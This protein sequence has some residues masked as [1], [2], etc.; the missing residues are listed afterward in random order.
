MDLIY[1]LIWNDSLGAFTVASELTRARGK[2][3]RRA[4]VVC[5]LMLAAAAMGGQAQSLPTGAEITV[6][7]G[8]ILQTGNT[9]TITQDTQNLA[10][11]WQ[12]FNVGAN[13]T[14]RFAQPNA[15]AIAL[16]RVLGSDPS[17]I[18]GA[19]E[20]NGQVWLLNPNGV[21]FG[22]GAQVNVGGLVAST[23]NISDADFLAGNRTLSGSGNGH[24]VNYGNI[25]ARDG[26]YVALLGGQVSN[27]GVVTARLGTVALASGER[28]TLD[29]AG[30][31]LL[32][33]SV[34]E[35]A[36]GA[37]V[38][39]Q[40]LI[41]ADG[42]R[43]FMT[44]R[45]SNAVL[46]TVVNNSGIVEARTV[47]REGGVIKLLGGFE[48]GT[49][50]VGGTLDASAPDGGDGGFIDTSGHKVAVADGVRITTGA[51]AGR[52]G[53]WLIDP[54][55]YTIAAT[56]G[57]ITGADLSALL[58]DN[59]V[60]IRSVDGADAN[61]NGDI[62]VNDA[63][64]WGAETTLTLEAVRNIEISDMISNTGSGNLVLR[65]DMQGVGVGTVKFLPGGQVSMHDGRTDLYYNPAT[66]SAPTNYSG[67][68]TGA[69]TAWMLVND[70]DQLQAINGN[71][72]GR[73]AL[74]RDI[75]ASATSGWNGGA[76]FAPIGSSSSPFT[77]ALDGLNHSI[78][79][80][81]INR[82]EAGYVGLFSY[83]SSSAAVS[84]LG[85]VN[86]DVTG[87]YNV[88]ALA[89]RSQGTIDGSH[90]TGTVTGTS[91]SV[92]GLLGWLS[93]GGAI[94]QSHS[95]AAVS[96]T[97][98]QVGGLVGYV[99]SDGSITQS[100]ATGTV[101]GDDRIGGLVGYVNGRGVISQ[102]HASAEVSGD[103]YVGGLVG[104]L[105]NG[106]S[107]SQSYSSGPVNGSGNKV[108]GLV[109]YLYNG[110]TITQSYATGAVSGSGSLGYVGGLVGHVID[111]HSGNNYGPS[112]VTE[113]YAVNTV[114]AAPSAY[115]GGLFGL[116][117]SSVAVVSRS[118]W[119]VEVSGRSNA[120]GLFN[121]EG[122]TGLTTSQMKQ[123]SNFADWSISGSGGG[124]TA[125]RIY[126]GQTRPLLRSFLTPLTVT[127]DDA[128]KTYDGVA[129]TGGDVSAS[130]FR[131]GE[132]V[133]D[134]LGEKTYTG[135]AQGA[136]D[137]GSYT[138][139][140]SGFY[141]DQQGYDIE[142]VPGTLTIEKRALGVTGAT[143]QSR[144]YD[145]TTDVAIQG[146][147][148]IGVLGSDTVTLTNANVGSFADKH[149]GEGKAVST[150]M[151][152]SGADANNYVL[153]QPVG[154][155][156][157]ITP[158]ELLVSATG[159]NRVYDGT[160]GATVTLS[161]DR[162][163]GDELSLS[164]GSAEFADK[165]AGEGK[166]VSVAGITVTGADA[167]NYTWNTTATAT[168]DIDR[169][170]LSV[171]GAMAQSRVYDGTTDVA[172]QGATLSG[173]FGSDAVILTNANVGSFADKHVGEGK[174]VSTAMGLSGA[175]ANNYVLT[176]P[177]G[178]TADIT[179]RELLVSVTG[180]NRV[181]DG[182]TAAT[183]MLSDDRVAGDQLALSYDSAEFADAAPGEGKRINVL[184]IAVDGADARNYTWNT[185]AYAT[186]DIVA[187][188]APGPGQPGPG[189]GPG[190]DPNPDPG[191][192][193][194]PV[195][196]EQV[197]P[198]ITP[199]LRFEQLSASTLSIEGGIRLPEGL[200]DEDQQD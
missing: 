45:A 73:Y 162:V 161:D 23:L 180:Q 134:L 24:I 177:V 17:Q 81:Y 32:N 108:G 3:P 120:D 153:T 94:S 199:E 165:H 154:L 25:S 66:Y 105:H 76:G 142:Y 119:D 160:T 117:E 86:V 198:E 88:G 185:V 96:S 195:A 173:L 164:Y 22:N 64:T 34:D 179:P 49:V 131:P 111:D 69:H 127:V 16:N 33:V 100:Y 6:G 124:N 55:D 7:Q 98:S 132:G 42:G 149:V 18:H 121:I 150:A 190:P 146:A 186:A 62:F 75:D 79:G 72:V 57:D 114:A 13:E 113:S 169:A 11:N 123:A 91:D 15:S 178:L 77:G 8:S 87:S 151:G 103:M 140:V 126:E 182:T 166:S 40:E 116:L 60:V 163:A 93:D 176:Q 30:D 112:S 95:A 102:S 5:G 51:S 48:G 61:G 193:W 47:E 85:L 80:L 43:V 138:L 27:Q 52:T 99:S 4:R 28:V 145:G 9:L 175:D 19:I 106:S 118:V 125:W 78:D 68:I 65:S 97:Y 20:A 168:A 39:N 38:D 157:D 35:G 122:A 83:L 130:G 1:K 194:A 10:I 54:N 181:Y 141:S 128:T 115:A 152:L 46:E 192:P 90:S 2:C 129:W 184:G 74:G 56:D 170:M 143:A 159:Q 37:L 109:G 196:L 59:N 63:V 155:T 44:A 144:V 200:V 31:A 50:N 82:P 135:T 41:R 104:W 136:R 189:P 110:S 26:G 107:V 36:L 147:T 133:E 197:L 172:I 183:V 191:E 71:L 29:F 156:A 21:L 148:L 53:T 158:R 67:N 92:G 101:S 58:A 137:A 139:A 14:V 188:D 70:I 89:G 174:A 167:G 187:A 12:Q 84:N 171:T